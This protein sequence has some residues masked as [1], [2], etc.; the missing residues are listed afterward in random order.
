[1]TAV[2]DKALEALKKYFSGKMHD[3]RTNLLG[4][5]RDLEKK[6]NTKSN[7]EQEVVKIWDRLNELNLFMNKKAD[8]DDTKKTFIYLE[9]K[10]N[11]LNTV[12]FKN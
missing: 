9:K 11:R 6:L 4:L 10:I 2:D 5:I 7:G 12:M 8:Q 3:L 1:M